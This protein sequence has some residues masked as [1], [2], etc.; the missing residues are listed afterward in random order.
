MKNKFLPALL[1]LLVILNLKMYFDMDTLG[2][3][4]DRTN[5]RIENV[6]S[7]I[8][9]IESNVSNT[10]RKIY[11]ANQWLYNVDYSILNITKDLDNVTITLKW[12]LHD[13]NAGSKVYLVY[14]A[15]DE[16]THEVTAWKEVLAGD[17]GNLNYKSQ[18]TLPYKKDY[19]FKVVAKN[20]KNIRSEKLRGIDFLSR[21]KGRIEINVNPKSKSISNNH[22]NLAFSASIENRYDLMDKELDKHIENN[23]LK[24]KNIKVKVYSNSEVKKEF[25]IMK[26]G[27]IVDENAKVEEPFKEIEDV[28]LEKIEV[29]KNVEY[30][31]KE[32]SNERIEVIIQDYLGRTYSRMSHGL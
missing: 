16:K 25:Q 29:S 7:N 4:L 12:S 17:M 30:D 23:L 10:M 15:E 26:D 8:N 32:D 31:S 5:D 24:L 21:L 11:D 18:L 20:N 6:N 1:V 13:L 28:K 3:R 14:G 27:K 9:N 19:Q 2:R 22:V